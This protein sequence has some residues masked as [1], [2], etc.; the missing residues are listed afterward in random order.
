MV[1]VVSNEDTRKL[2]DERE[3]EVLV[4][5]VLGCNTRQSLDYADDLLLCDLHGEQTVV[6]GPSSRRRKIA[7]PDPESSMKEEDSMSWLLVD[8]A[9]AQME[10]AQHARKNAD[11][12]MCLCIFRAN[13][14]RIMLCCKCL[15]SGAEWQGK[16][17]EQ[18]AI[19]VGLGE[20]AS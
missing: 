4:S 8:I 3:R 1:K 16:R 11:A 15:K 14:T 17:I 6:N 20:T 13:R 5:L 9:T 7:R 19:G 10:D 12:R 2:F 18:V